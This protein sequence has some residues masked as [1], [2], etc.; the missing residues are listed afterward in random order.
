MNIKL[1][2]GAGKEIKDGFINHDISELNSID[3]VH[4]L[5]S[6]PWP[7]EDSSVDYILMQDV[8]E[9]LSDTVKPMNELNRI[10]KKGGIV[11]IRVPYWNSW[12]AYADPTHKRYFHEHTFHFFDV[13]SSYFLDRDY[14]TE[15]CFE[16][17]SEAL[18]L[19]PGAP[20][21]RI[22]K[23]GLI[24]IR[25]SI[26]RRIVGWLGNH[27]GNIINDIEVEMMKVDRP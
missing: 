2:L 18:I 27:V 22:P 7:W 6:Y 23:L 11:K 4:N 17:I 12:C 25:N 19:A 24:Y 8:L 21:F 14:Y 1:N 5:D 15:G 20:Y 3:I 9:H 26:M 13:N 16:I 10:L